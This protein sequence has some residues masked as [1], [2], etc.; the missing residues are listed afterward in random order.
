MSEVTSEVTQPLKAI[1]LALL[2]PRP[3][4]DTARLAAPGREAEWSAEQFHGLPLVERIRM[5]AAG[6]V[7][8]FL[9]G[10]EIP[11]REALK[12]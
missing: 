2:A 3:T 11:A 5:L 6:H 7:H 1:D 10:T 4:F 8:F 12:E 9:R